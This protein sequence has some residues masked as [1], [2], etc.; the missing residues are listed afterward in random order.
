[1]AD[2]LTSSIRFTQPTI[3]GDTTLWGEFLNTNW[4]YADQAINQAV[5][6]PLLDANLVLISDGTSN[7]NARY[8]RMIFT[9]AQT[10]NHT[11]TMPAVARDGL[12]TNSTTGGF[13]VT[14]TT[15]AGRTA[16]ILP[17]VTANYFCDGSNVDVPTIQASTGAITATTGT[18]SGTLTSNGLLLVNNTIDG[19]A[20][21][22]AGNT[23]LNALTTSGTLTSNGQLI[24]NNTIFG[25][26]LLISGDTALVNVTASNGAFSG[27]TVGGIAVVTNNAGTYGINISG[28]A[29][30]ATAVSGGSVN[31]TT[32]VFSGTV[33]SN[34]SSSST[35]SGWLY[36]SGGNA[37][38]P[39][40]S[41]T[42]GMI[43][44]G[45]GMVA[46]S[47]L[48]NSDAR[49]KLD[50]EDIGSDEALHWLNVTR[51]VTYRKLFKH[52]AAPETAIPEAGVIAQ[53]QVAAGYGRYVVAHP[54]EGMPPTV[55]ADGSLSDAGVQLSLPL[56]YQVAYLT[57]ALKAA[58]QR[59]ET[60][61]NGYV[62]F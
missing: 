5:T 1:M 32:G 56:M 45:G 27:L 16:Q 23:A 48:A 19:N 54:C 15:G 6:I 31:A 46:S 12:V 43:A 51:P 22:I 41:Y 47:F 26:T 10:G 62:K 2:P 28:G 59:I 18:F 17:G 40:A 44:A 61:E 30:V 9:G 53:E 24:V 25:N 21:N 34:G 39:S 3:G 49:L 38:F 60:L 29:A 42:F 52:D 8:H 14:L 11:V 7:D 4:G 57:A 33:Q 13:N 58:L 35:F 50:V 36:N 37:A 20:L 55:G